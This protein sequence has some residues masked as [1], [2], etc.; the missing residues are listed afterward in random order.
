V[1]SLRSLTLGAM[2]VLAV[3]ACGSNDRGDAGGGS[4]GSGKGAVDLIA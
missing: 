2:L 3:T 1:L 4:S